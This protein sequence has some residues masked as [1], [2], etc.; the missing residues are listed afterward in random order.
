M[1]QGTGEKEVRLLKKTL[2][3]AGVATPRALGDALQCY[4][5]LKLIQKRF[6]EAEVMF[7]CPDLKDG[8][9][10]FKD[11]NLS[12]NPLYSL[13]DRSWVLRNFQRC[14]LSKLFPKISNGS[15]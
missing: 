1:A 10:V 5:T 6:H 11:L 4:V 7:F 15:P 12:A 3:V 13:I 2:A 9:F 14:L 8:I